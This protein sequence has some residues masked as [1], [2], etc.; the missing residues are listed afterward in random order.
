MKSLNPAALPLFIPLRNPDNTLSPDQNEHLTLSILTFRLWM[1]Y[2]KAILN[3][4]IIIG[5]NGRCL[6]SDIVPVRPNQTN[7]LIT[8]RPLFAIGETKVKVDKAGY[9]SFIQGYLAGG[10]P[11]YKNCIA[12]LNLTGAKF[13]DGIILTTPRIFTQDK[14]S[15]ASR[16][17]VL[18]FKSELML[19]KG[20]VREEHRKVEDVIGEE[21]HIFILVTDF[22]SR[23]DG[24]TYEDNEVVITSND[25]RF[26]GE[27]LARIKLHSAARF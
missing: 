16:R 15:V 24:E 7:P 3:K 12:F 6:L 9:F 10:I 13:A 22:K 17:N 27:E 21:E 25:K 19:P 1:C 2:Q 4:D 18:D 11:E 8:F 14:G 5:D 26:F 20:L 23:T